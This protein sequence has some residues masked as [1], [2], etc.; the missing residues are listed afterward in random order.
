[1]LA[2]SIDESNA[3]KRTATP[4]EYSALRNGKNVR[5]PQTSWKPILRM[6]CKMQSRKPLSVGDG[7]RLESHL[8]LSI[9]RI[10]QRIRQH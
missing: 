2:I 7:D 10:D 5:K 9:C 1:M 6:I 4:K 3:C 8:K